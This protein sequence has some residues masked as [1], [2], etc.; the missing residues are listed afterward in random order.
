MTELGQEDYA[1]SNGLLENTINKDKV[2]LTFYSRLDEPIGTNDLFINWGIFASST[3]TNLSYVNGQY[4]PYRYNTILT[5]SDHYDREF[6]F[7]SFC[8]SAVFSLAG[9]IA[10]PA[11]LIIFSVLEVYAGWIATLQLRNLFKDHESFK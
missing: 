10:W 1:V 6:L 5:F 9:P 7:V 11:Q 3:D 4:R 2:V 8:V